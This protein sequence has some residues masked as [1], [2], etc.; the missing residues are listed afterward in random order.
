M[1]KMRKQHQNENNNDKKRWR[2][3]GDVSGWWLMD[4]GITWRE[5][6][7]EIHIHSCVCSRPEFLCQRT[8]NTPTTHH[9]TSH[10]KRRIWSNMEMDLVWHLSFLS[11]FSLLPS[12]FF[13]AYLVG[14]FRSERDEV[15]EHVRILQMSGGVPLLSVDE[16]GEED[17][18]SIPPQIINDKQPFWEISVREKPDEEN[19][20][21][22]SNQI[23]VPL[24]GIKLN[25]KPSG[26]SHCIRR[27]RFPTDSAESNS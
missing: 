15:P 2:R 4:G 6:R 16:G 10:H 23:P 7:C 5:H 1:K 9:T 27:P 25:G 8:G 26:V 12:L 19:G 18:V 24:L 11:L 22:V 14:G 3:G 13:S 17:R 20:C 21:V